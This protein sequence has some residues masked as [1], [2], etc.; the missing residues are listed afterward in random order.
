MTMSIVTKHILRLLLRII[1]PSVTAE[2]KP[3]TVVKID[4]KLIAEKT[5]DGRI[6]IYEV[7]E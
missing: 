5:R 6:I 7:I 2:L 4:E 1:K 3:G